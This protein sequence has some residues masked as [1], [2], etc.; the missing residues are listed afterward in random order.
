MVPLIKNLLAILE[1]QLEGESNIFKKCLKIIFNRKGK[2]QCNK[3]AVGWNEWPRFKVWTSNHNAEKEKKGNGFSTDIR[4]G[5]TL[6]TTVLNIDSS[7]II[8]HSWWNTAFLF[9]KVLHGKIPPSVYNF[10]WKDQYPDDF[11]GLKSPL[12][13]WLNA[14]VQHGLTIDMYLSLLV[15]LSC[16]T[17]PTVD[18]S[19][20][21]TIVGR[22]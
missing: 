15:C 16:Y 6:L 12:S 20:C 2:L 14:S 5:S 21:L 10:S 4:L 9:V 7:E 13:F 3:I 11:L 17:F 18:V 1:D 19:L 22:R 8:K